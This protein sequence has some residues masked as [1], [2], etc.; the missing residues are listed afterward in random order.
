MSL[1]YPAIHKLYSSLKSLEQFRKENNLF[2]SISYLDNFFSEYRNITFM[3]QKSLKGTEFEKTYSRNRDKFLSNQNSKWF[4]EQRN[5]TVKEHPFELEKRIKVT[6]Y[7][8]YNSVILTN[9]TFTINNDTPAKDIIESLRKF[10]AGFNSL[11]IFFSVEFFFYKK[12]T[13]QELWDDIVTGV[14]NMIAFMEAMKADIGEHC[15]LCDHLQ[16]EI[17]KFHVFKIPKELLFIDDYVYYRQEDQFEKAA[18]GLPFFHS[19][20][21]YCPV[22][23]TFN[24]AEYVE[25]LGL[26]RKRDAFE[27]MVVMHAIIFGEQKSLMPVFVIIHKDGTG[28]F[29]PYLASLKTVGYRK[30]NEIAQR[31]KH[32]KIEQV[33]YITEA[34]CYKAEN[35]NKVMNL[36]TPDRQ[37]YVEKEQLLC[38]KL[39]K[40]G[41]NLL[42][43]LDSDKIS[44]YN[45]IRC[46]LK[47]QLNN[48]K[49]SNL[50]ITTIQPIIDAFSSL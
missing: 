11:E 30:I 27:A 23:M 39:C 21:D 44:C 26:D 24:I 48:K 1:L 16:K 47:N 6:L 33:F 3:L 41:D 37:P 49:S 19:E 34:F 12:E 46:V 50:G 9:N 10:F 31:V 20:K 43:C 13:N 7:T 35:M 40:S 2:E 8:P 14:Y 22:K 5:E 38:Y 45:Y 36:A 4:I 18:K 25:K 28:E 32:E 29:V 17:G 15:E 42:I